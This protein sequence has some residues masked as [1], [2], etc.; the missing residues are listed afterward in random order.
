M[1]ERTNER[2]HERTNER[3]HERTNER[4]HERTN[5]RTH[6]RTDER[7][8]VR[9][10]NQSDARTDAR[11]HGLW[12]I[13]PIANMEG[14]KRRF[15]V[16]AMLC[17]RLVPEQHCHATEPLFWCFYVGAAPMRYN[18]P[19]EQEPRR[20][21]A[22]RGPEPQCGSSPSWRS[23]AMGW[24]QTNRG[25]IDTPSDTFLSPGNPKMPAPPPC[26]ASALADDVAGAWPARLISNADAQPMSVQNITL[27]KIWTLQVI[28]PNPRYHLLL[29]VSQVPI[30]FR[31]L[32]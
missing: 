1:N 12:S 18:W 27:H 3:T 16:A 17:W 32:V 10:N 7:T 26:S 5:A 25:G 19:I 4:T 9:T 28:D 6:A 2:M 23:G 22:R 20:A 21:A 15:R 31:W 14:A 11:M 30:L 24:L 8:Y 13:T 29:H